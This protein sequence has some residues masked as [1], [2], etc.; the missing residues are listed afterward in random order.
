MLQPILCFSVACWVVPYDEFEVSWDHAYQQNPVDLI[1]AR[2][3]RE[4]ADFEAAIEQMPSE[5]AGSYVW[6]SL[7]SDLHGSRQT[8]VVRLGCDPY[9]DSSTQEHI[10]PVGARES[11][12]SHD[13]QTGNRQDYS[14]R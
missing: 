8:G 10:E 6:K 13:E 11:Q 9:A 4:F 14:D 2:H 12:Y 7:Q 1:L 3:D 5:G